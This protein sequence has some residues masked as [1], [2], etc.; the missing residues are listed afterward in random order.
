MFF[1]LNDA[2]EVFRKKVQEIYEREASPLVE[3][4]EGKGVFLVSS[5]VMATWP[6]NLSNTTS[7]M[8]GS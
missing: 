6:N 1:E 3:E 2:Q 4:Y 7:G 5:A 8:P